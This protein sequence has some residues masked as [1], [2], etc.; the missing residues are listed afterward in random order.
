M[1]NRPGV[2]LMRI[3]I[4]F[5]F[6]NSIAAIVGGLFLMKSGID[7]ESGFIIFLS[8]L[9]IILFPIEAFITVL[10]LYCLGQIC[11]NIEDMRNI[12]MKRENPEYSEKTSSAYGQFVS[13]YMVQETIKER[14]DARK[15]L[16]A[17]QA[18]KPKQP[19]QPKNTANMQ[20]PVKDNKSK[21]PI[22]ANKRAGATGSND[23]Q[24]FVC[25]IC[26]KKLP[27]AK[28]YDIIYS[29]KKRCAC[30]DCIQTLKDNKEG[31]SILSAPKE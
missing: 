28:K 14:E 5:F 7:S 30:E 21:Q 10:P 19:K 20:Q 24:G 13:H 27:I 3:C 26:G 18:N 12:E 16:E 1:F 22:D 31:F 4:F 9:I 17:R 11:A 8:I 25:D 23:L 2:K 29:G 6:L 15:Y